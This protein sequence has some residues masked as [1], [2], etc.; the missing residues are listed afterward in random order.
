MRHQLIKE[1]KLD[2]TIVQD[3]YGTN[4]HAKLSMKQISDKYDIPY[5]QVQ[6]FL[7]DEKIKN[8]T[9]ENLEAIAISNQ[10]NPLSVIEQFFQSVHHAGKELAFT[11]ILAQMLREEIATILAEEGG[12]QALTRGD[13]ADIYRQW[14][15]ISD[16]LTKH[17]MNAK[18]H[19]EGYITLFAQVLDLQ[20]EVSYVKIIT[21]ILSKEDPALYRKIQ[22]ALDADPEAKK[23]LET[24][25]NQDVYYYWNSKEN[26]ISKSNKSQLYELDN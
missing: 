2:K 22:R 26:Q 18:T 20:R 23:V 1:R 16:K 24:L 11:A 19:L 13:N 21:E 10:F 7:R 5:T 15:A 14:Y 9:D 12:V 17:H 3:Y 4:G 25:S 6:A 8:Y